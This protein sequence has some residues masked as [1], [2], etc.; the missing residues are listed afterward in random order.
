MSERITRKDLRTDKFA[1]A[2]EHNV[3]Y[4]AA[5]RAQ[6]IRYSLIGLAV[7]L[8]GGAIYFYRGYLHEQRQVKLAD[9]IQIQETAV[10]AGVTPGPLAFPTDDAK[11]DAATKAFAAVTS[12][13]GDSREGLIAQYYLGSIAAD[14]G[15]LDEARKRYQAVADSSDKDYSSLA[16][17]SLAELDYLENKPSEGEKVLRDL[18]AH[19][20]IMVSKDQATIALARHLGKTNPAEARKLLEPI[21]SR[22]TGAAQTA[23][24]LL[25]ELQNQ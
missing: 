9:A 14:A 10:T 17:L 1:V 6:V 7:I 25:G 20:T 21:T 22:T 18:I 15:K 19:P 24:Q 12:E 23:V 5:H 13:Y 2:V 3:E 16:K 4:M 11:R 8:I